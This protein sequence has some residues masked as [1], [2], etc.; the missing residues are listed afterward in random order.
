M[1]STHLASCDGNCKVCHICGQFRD[2][3]N[4][5]VHD[6]DLDFCNG[7]RSNLNMLLDSKEPP[8]SGW[9]KLLTA[10]ECQRNT[11]LNPEQRHKQQLQNG[12]PL[13]VLRLY[14]LNSTDNSFTL[15]LLNSTFDK[16]PG[17]QIVTVHAEF[18]T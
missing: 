2:I 3:R 5:N 9:T 16:F 8:F 12:I 17:D 15:R 13:E 4:Q 10:P 11:K 14:K 1:E 18:Q 7:P 6:L